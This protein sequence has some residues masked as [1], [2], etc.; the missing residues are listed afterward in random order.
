MSAGEIER[1]LEAE[2][3]LGSPRA[4]VMAEL[5]RRGA[6]YDAPLPLEEPAGWTTL[7]VYMEQP[8]WAGLEWAATYEKTKAW[9]DMLFDEGEV[10]QAIQ[11]EVREQ[12]W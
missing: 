3:P 11:A 6:S 10:L 2:F 7:R 4:A 12:T 9:A 8:W 1:R 5:L